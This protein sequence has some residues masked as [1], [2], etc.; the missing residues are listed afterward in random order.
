ML[1]SNDKIRELSFKI[2]Q[3]IDSSP[4]SELETNIHALI[5]G[6]LTK[7]ELVSREEFD[8]QTALL[9]RTQQQLRVLEEKISTLEQAH[10]SEK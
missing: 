2:K 3:L 8:I 7:M 1:F 4:I 10:T 6:M 9:A 5:Q